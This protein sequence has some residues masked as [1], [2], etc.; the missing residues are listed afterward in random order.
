MR[1]CF[2]LSLLIIIVVLV[3]M[4]K[5][6]GAT[7]FGSSVAVSA[8]AGVTED[9]PSIFVDSNGKIHAVWYQ[10][11]STTN[12]IRYSSSTD[13]INF[14]SPVTVDSLSSANNVNPDIAVDS[15]DKIFVVWRSGSDI[16][17]SNS[18]DGSTWGTNILVDN[19]GG[20][21]SSPAIAIDKNNYIH[22][23]WDDTRN[24]NYDIFYAKS[25]DNG[26]TFGGNKRVD[27]TGS[28]ISDQR[29]PDI[30]VDS[31]DNIH[32]VW[33]DYR[34]GTTWDIYYAKSI[35]GGSSFGTNKKVDDSTSGA[36]DNPSI[37][38]DVNNK[39]HVSWSDTRNG[40][41]DIYYAN[42]T[43]GASFNPN[44]PVSIG[45]QDVG[46]VSIGVEGTYIYVVWQDNRN[47]N[48]DIYYKE[49]LDGGISFTGETTVYSGANN[50]VK[51]TISVKGYRNVV[52][53]DFRSD[54]S[55]DIYFARNL[56]IPPNP[57]TLN[58]P[59]NDTWVITSTPKFTWSFSDPD[60]GDSQS[61]YQVQ[62]ADNEGFTSPVYDSGE[63][64]SSLQQHTTT[65]SIS[66]G[67]WWWRVRTKDSG[68]VFG[69]WAKRYVKIDT[70]IPT[71]SAPTDSGLWITSKEITWSWSASVDSPSGI[72]GYNI[73]IGTT[74]GG[75]DIINDLWLGNITTY[76]Y[77]YG[78]NGTTY[79]AKIRAKDNAGNLGSYGLSSDGITVDIT[80]PE[81]YAPYPE[82]IYSPTSSVK[83]SW[84]GV[85]D[86]PSGIEGYY[87]SIGNVPNGNDIV[88]ELWVGNILS[89]TYS[90]GIDGKTY[91][92]KIKAK[93]FAGNIGSYSDSSS[94]TTVDTTKPSKVVVLDDGLYTTS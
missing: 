51:P 85:S 15:N 35:D 66:D 31:S 81:A 75:S 37:A 88:N 20:I 34:S 12:R 2:L 3:L 46:N 28:G 61:G 69:G 62:I 27:D 64:T 42:S 72:S 43:T 87:I 94:G 18:T 5:N 38:V 55:G 80:I 32:I 67:Y 40:N 1:R 70:S 91:Y 48:Y 76:K 83:F 6:E 68:G 93:D 77:S 19:S 92:A 90:S 22:V 26:S 54:A 47:A 41:Y 9:E 24:G 65:S 11:I 89:Y 36:Q 14:A 56:N 86:Y 13:G 84:I 45:A 82:G 52:W 39:I 71:T 58:L 74:L 49:S 21:C 79:Y 59:E 50:Q 8:T 63:V 16:Y 57:P 53:Q 33:Q 60:L 73:S 23:S 7:T 4:N 44:V 78:V 17:I 30:A 29:Y 10:Y 25:I